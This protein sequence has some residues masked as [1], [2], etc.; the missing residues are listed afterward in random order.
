MG[1]SRFRYPWRDL[2]CFRS[3]AKNDTIVITDTILC[4]GCSSW[5][6]KRCSGI[7]GT[8]KP[9][10]SFRCERCIGMI[11]A[12]DGRPMI[13]VTV[14]REKLD[15]V[16]FFCYL[17]E[18][19][20][21]SGGCELASTTKFHLFCMGQIQRA[22]DH[23]YT[24]PILHQLQRTICASGALCSMQAKPVPTHLICIA[25]STMTALWSAGCAGSPTKTKIR[26]Q[27]LIERMQSGD[28]EKVL[29]T[30]RL[31]WHG[32]VRRIDGWLKKV[33]NLN[34]GGGRGRPKKTSSEVIRLDCLALGLLPYNRKAWGGTSLRNAIRLCPPPPLH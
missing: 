5:V 18:F 25:C 27:D 4:D 33:Q 26:S 28:L 2:V 7:S 12:V 10:P 17:G 24:P 9:N 29:R 20:F 13:E 30:R 34:P 3:P 22:P 31:R 23:P 21:S 32:Y 14:G 6:H 8:L 16:P 19:L 11:R 1:K 15:V